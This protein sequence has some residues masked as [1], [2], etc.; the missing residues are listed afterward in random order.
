MS[1][2]AFSWR[3]KY[4]QYIM[5]ICYCKPSQNSANCNAIIVYYK[6]IS[7]PKTSLCKR[8][9]NRTNCTIRIIVVIKGLLPKIIPKY[10]K[11]YYIYSHVVIYVQYNSIFNICKG[12]QSFSS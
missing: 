12:T 1:F 10:N 6:I 3:I 8:T 11:L 5:N 7:S 9:Y 2:P 4:V